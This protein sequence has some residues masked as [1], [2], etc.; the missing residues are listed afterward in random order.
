MN[1]NVFFALLAF[2]VPTAFAETPVNLPKPGIVD[3]QPTTPFAE[4]YAG[5]E[6]KRDDFPIDIEAGREFTVARDSAVCPRIPVSGD[7]RLFSSA[8]LT[9]EHFN[10]VGRNDVALQEEQKYVEYE[11]CKAVKK[12]QTLKV[13][14]LSILS[15][16]CTPPLHT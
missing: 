11:I 12:G 7:Q 15:L 5:F 8:G 9:L 2:S 13:V 16:G 10:R 3:V 6:T 1:R 14:R 4:T